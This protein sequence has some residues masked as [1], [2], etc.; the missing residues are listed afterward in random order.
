[1]WKESPTRILFQTKVKE[2]EKV[3]ISN[4]AIELYEAIPQPKA[5]GEKKAA[6][7][8]AAP[9]SAEPISQDIFHAIGKYVEQNAELVGRVGIVYQFRLLGP[10][11][12]WTIDLKNGKGAV[13]NGANTAPECTLELSDADF[14]AMCTGKADAQKLYFG[15]KLKISGNVM[16]SQKLEFLKKLD[17]NLVVQIARERAGGAAASTG[18]AG[19]GGPT[20]QEPTSSDIFGVIGDYVSQHPE[21]VAKVQTVYLFKLTGPDSKWTLDLKN[22]KGG[23]L[24]GDGVAPECTLEL[25]E[26]DFM[27]M[28]GG[29]A[30][31]QKLYFG[32]KMKI[33]GN[34]MASQKLQELFKGLKPAD[35]QKMLAERMGKGAPKPEAPKA[36]PV[37]GSAKKE[38]AN[39]SKIFAA[40]AKRLGE[41]KSLGAELGAGTVQFTVGGKSWLVSAAGV[42]DGAD[43]KANA[44]LT[45]SDEH[46]TELVK[47]TRDA[48]DMFMKGE[49]RSDGD[50]RYAQKL[51]MLKGLV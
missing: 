51:G 15:G 10:D 48:R 35:A 13:T 42:K 21:L 12:V 27:D 2:R 44:T 20:A 11:S 49:L 16:A 24:E 29:K 25:A 3:V 17:P 38:E 47:G 14:M 34:V 19:T 30:D 5:K 7:T 39:A 22:G 46:L 50:V 32:G 31:P 37:V 18:D 23:A 28:V 40:L 8:A 9:T 6:A 4:A 43:P 33:S 45:I 1:M 36:A 41:N 26:S